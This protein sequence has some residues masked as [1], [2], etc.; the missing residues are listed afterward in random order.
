MLAGPFPSLSA[1]LIWGRDAV[2][3]GQFHRAAPLTQARQRPSHELWLHEIKR[4]C[5][6]VIA[7]KDG[8]RAPRPAPT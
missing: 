5:F 3:C 8:A 1:W 2:A 6:R 4:D 7:R